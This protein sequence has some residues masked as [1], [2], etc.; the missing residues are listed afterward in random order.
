MLHPNCNQIASDETT[1]TGDPF[2]TCIEIVAVAAHDQHRR[3]TLPAPLA[4]TLPETPGARIPRLWNALRI[5]FSIGRQQFS[6]TRLDARVR[7]V[8]LSPTGEP[9]EERI[10]AAAPDMSHTASHGSPDSRA[11]TDLGD[12][13]QC[14]PSHGT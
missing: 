14:Q 12:Y 8:G 5:G 9:T 10:R 3:A 13:R 6:C 7:R 11:R 2:R 1:E 4:V